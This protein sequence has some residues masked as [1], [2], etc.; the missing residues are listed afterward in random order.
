MYF[1]SNIS[2]YYQNLIKISNMKKL[3]K[4]LYAIAI[5][6]FFMKLLNVPLSS[7]VI[8]LSLMIISGMYL[9]LGFAFFSNIP[10]KGAF[11]S[12]TYKGIK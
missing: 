10:L 12:D 6:G 1:V 11:N 9:V 8:F 4:I 3:E 7:M 5:A 2:L